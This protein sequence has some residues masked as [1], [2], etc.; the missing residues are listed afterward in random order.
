M[1]EHHEYARTAADYAAEAW[2]HPSSTNE[3]RAQASRFLKLPLELDV[4]T[5]ARHDRLR[6]GIYR[7]W[8][9]PH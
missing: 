6:A 8:P 3:Q 7:L 4:E 9:E 2:R 5:T 1:R